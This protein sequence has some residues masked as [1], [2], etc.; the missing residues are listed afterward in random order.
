[1]DVITAFTL[2]GAIIFLGFISTFIFER[3]RIPDIVW[4]MVLG[5][6]VG[7]V[8]GIVDIKDSDMLLNVTK[9][10]AA[11]ALALI[12][13]DGGLNMDV[14]KTMQEF[15][16]AAV[17]AVLNVVFSIIAM[18][19][20]SVFMLNWTLLDGILLG[21]IVG[22]SSSAIV[23]P[24]V[25]SLKIREKIITMLSLESAITDVL[26]IVTAIT[27]L[28]IIVKGT[29]ATSEVIHSIA[30]SFSIGA[31][32]GIMTGI[33]WLYFS[34]ELAKLQWSY[35]LNLVAILIVYAGVEYIHGSGAIAVLLFGIILG[36]SETIGNSLKIKKMADVGRYDKETKTFQAEVT[37]FI[38]VF[39]FVFLG[40]IVSIGDFNMII[41]GVVLGA[42]LLFAR[43][44]PA[45]ASSIKTD[46]TK[47][48]KRLMLLMAPRGL[49]AAV[50]A[51]I[52]LIA[53]IPNA[54]I[55]PDVV[56]VIILTSIVISVFGVMTM[57]EE[58]N[59]AA[60]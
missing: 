27:V 29:V 56:F 45:E 30:S 43:I 18:S 42:A 40:I 1:M 5:L 16:R 17:L 9:I 37:F 48:E 41:A 23:I 14:K 46:I 33:L 26:C 50:L 39:F 55:F 24:L 10:F 60:A 35:R 8:F 34:Q 57:K 36:N 58:K 13:F 12:L 32:L 7:P 19:A 11:L 38:R 6:L 2:F 4:L 31:M 21:A 44:I 49:A 20:I 47:Q 28:E 54:Y 59:N 3:T 51:Q 22:G 15:P 53:G 25:R 52:P